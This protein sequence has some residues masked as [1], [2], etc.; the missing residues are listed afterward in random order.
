M[1][2]VAVIGRFVPVKSPSAMKNQKNT[3]WQMPMA[4][5]GAMVVMTANY[6]LN[7]DPVLRFV[8]A[9]L[10][11]CWLGAVLGCAVFRGKVER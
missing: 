7:P 4:S 11:L 3:A 5:L 8:V 9:S 1:N 10:C 2:S 6:W